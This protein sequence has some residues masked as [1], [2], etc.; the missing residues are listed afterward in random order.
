ML[1]LACMSASLLSFTSLLPPFPSYLISFPPPPSLPLS[2]PLYPSPPFLLC[3]S[4]LP[5]PL[6]SPSPT[7]Y[8]PHLP[9]TSYLSL[10]PPPSVLLLYPLPLSL[11][12]SLLFSPLSPAD[13]MHMPIPVGDFTERIALLRLN[14]DEGLED[15]YADVDLDWN[16]TSY[17]SKL[18]INKN[19]NRY[20]NII[21]CTSCVTLVSGYSIL[22]VWG[23]GRI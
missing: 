19:K 5:L 4:L 17:A 15:E 21:P 9:S 8:V 14:D 1:L 13:T 22:R 6:C 10:L 18:N 23:Y 16:F 12:F 2:L 20:V 7:L 11:F 3:R